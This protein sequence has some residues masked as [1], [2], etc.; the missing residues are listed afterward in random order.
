M[1]VVEVTRMGDMVRMVTKD[2]GG[3]APPRDRQR[4]GAS[5][6]RAMAE[7]FRVS[8]ETAAEFAR[9]H[10]IGA[11][12]VRRW[13]GRSG[14]ETAGPTVAPR[15]AATAA[16]TVS[17]APVRIAAP[18]AAPAGALEIAI[19]RAV[20]RVGQSFDEDVLRRVVG[21]LAEATRC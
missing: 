5:D 13:A 15:A 7:A 18:T 19:G 10:G 21:I 11:W 2:S 6:G 14:A 17:F 12:R 20:I 9:R 8:G 1:C 4:W 16:A 3:W